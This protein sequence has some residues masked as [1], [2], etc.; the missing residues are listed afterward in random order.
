MVR[1][2][3]PQGP[4][5]SPSK[6]SPTFIEKPGIPI[7]ENQENNENDNK[8][9]PTTKPSQGPTSSP[10][11]VAMSESP[12]E[13]MP[14]VS[15]S[16]NPSDSPSEYFVLVPT[17]GCEAAGETFCKY[18]DG[19]SEDCKSCASFI[20]KFQCD[21]DG[22]PDFGAKG[23]KQWCFPPEPFVL[24]KTCGCKVAGLEFCNYDYGSMV[25]CESCTPFSSEVQCDYDGLSA[26]GAE[27]CKQ[28]CFPL[29]NGSN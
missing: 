10:C 20:S 29:P 16:V 15:P 19:S 8:A 18:D 13:L 6:A 2:K 1:I 17:C 11:I 24:E 23:C 7:I 9:P 21:L 5:H 28:W 27:D 4:P 26:A 3:V 22:L 14:S 12:I 25:H